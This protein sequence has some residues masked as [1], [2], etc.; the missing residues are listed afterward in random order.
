MAVPQLDIK[1]VLWDIRNALVGAWSSTLGA[2][3]VS[4]KPLTYIDTG[5]L[6]GVVVA[7]PLPNVVCK[8]AKV[9]AVIGN[10]GFVYIGPANVGPAA[11]ASNP[12]TGFQL[13]SGDNT[14][15]LPID[16]LNRLFYVCTGAGDEAIWM[17]LA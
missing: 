4:H 5:E 9:M 14:G 10:S 12:N 3:L 13:G 6:G 17:I 11:A 1:V 15:W 16:N 8:Y 7:T 2:L